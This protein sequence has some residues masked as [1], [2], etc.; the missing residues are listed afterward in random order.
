M[1]SCKSLEDAFY[2][3]LSGRQSALAKEWAGFPPRNAPGWILSRGHPILDPILWFFFTL[4]EKQQCRKGRKSLFV[5]RSDKRITCKS[6]LFL[7]ANFCYT[8]KYENISGGRGNPIAQ[9]E[10]TT[11]YGNAHLSFQ[12]LERKVGDNLRLTWAAK[13][14]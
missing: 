5:G 8:L 14:P 4:K 6:F 12:L 7:W 11:G 13:W 1:T 2:L 3:V 10:C 9:K